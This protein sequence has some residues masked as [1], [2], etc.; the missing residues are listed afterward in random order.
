MLLRASY[1]RH[2]SEEVGGNYLI[3]RLKI[4]N[5]GRQTEMFKQAETHRHTCSSTRRQVGAIANADYILRL[6]LRTRK[7]IHKLGHDYGIDQ[8]KW[9]IEAG[10]ASHCDLCKN[11][12][13]S[14]PA[15]TETERVSGAESKKP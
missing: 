13:T 9:F 6:E 8:E 12:G 3:S 11:P 1:C 14:N 7:Q 4:S 10:F 5:H 2:R 15:S